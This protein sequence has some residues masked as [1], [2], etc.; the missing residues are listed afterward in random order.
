MAS[1][2]AITGAVRWHQLFRGGPHQRLAFGVQRGGCLVQATITAHLHGRF[3][4]A[5]M[6]ILIEVKSFAGKIE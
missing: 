3:V 5:K 1:R 2:W 4:H 6:K